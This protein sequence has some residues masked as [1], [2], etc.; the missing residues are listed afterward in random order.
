MPLSDISLHGQHD[1][2][3][4]FTVIYL[5]MEVTNVVIKAA[6]FSDSALEKEGK[7]DAEEGEPGS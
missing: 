1:N 3:Q 4:L 2:H 6:L 5:F 7:D